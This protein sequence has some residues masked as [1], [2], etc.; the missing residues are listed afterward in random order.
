MKYIMLIRNDIPKIKFKKDHLKHEAEKQLL[1]EGR[2]WQK[3]TL[4]SWRLQSRLDRS[5]TLNHPLTQAAAEV[6]VTLEQCTN[7]NNNNTTH[8]A[9]SNYETDLQL[10]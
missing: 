5:L 2:I 8:N 9:G 10:A 6:L 7:R 1:G 4:Q 3:V